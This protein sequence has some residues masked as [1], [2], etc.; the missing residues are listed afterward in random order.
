MRLSCVV[1]IFVVVAIITLPLLAQSP[2][3]NINGLVSDPATG[4]ITG[5]EIVAV[6][7]GTGVQYTTK[8]NGEGI[9]FL[10]NLPPG[11]YRLQVSKVGFK[12]II[13]PD[14][15]LN[16]QDALSV[17]FTLP[18][19]ALHEIVTVE[20]GA[21]LV[22]TE[23]PAVSTVVD[24]QFAE[25]LPMNGRSFQTLIQLTP[26]VVLTP[27]GITDSGQFSVN[28]QRS[29]S[30]YWMVDGVSANIGI[31]VNLNGNPGN[32]LAGASGAFSALGGTNS[33]VSVDAMQ[34]FRI[35]T[36]TFAPEFG[37]TPGAQISIVTRSGTNQLHGTLFDYLRN[38]LFDANDW[39]ADN[40]HL[41]KPQE[42][43]NDFGG[44]FSGPIFK[45]RTFFFF[46][47]EGLRLRLPQV[48]QTEV[49]DF[50][51]R[52]SASAAIQPY[53][54]AFPL[55]NG[56]D[57]SSTGTAQFN[58]SFSN[59]STLD[60][61]SIRVDHR[62]NNKVTLFGRYSYSPSEIDV[63]GG[64][65]PSVVS[66][67]NINT[68]TAT[69]GTTWLPTSTIVNDLRVNYSRV[70]ARGSSNLDNFG[71]ALPLASVPYPAPFT[72][73]DA[74]FSFDILSITPSIE[75]GD[76]QHQR[77]K[78]FN[79]LEN[80]STQRG[81]HSLKFGIDFRRLSPEFNPA[82][83]SQ[84]PFFTDVSSAETGNMLFSIVESSR[85]GTLLFRNLGIF[86]E[87]TWGVRPRLTLTYG[88]RWDVDFAPTSVNG[89]S[90]TAAL[91]FGNPSNIALAP[92]GTP[93]FHTPFGGIAP[94]LGFAYELPTRHNWQTI[95]RGGVG[96]FYDL[97][98][99]ELGNGVFSFAYP[100]GNAVLTSGGQFPLDPITAAPPTISPAEASSSSGVI[101]LFDP[102]L[103]LPRTFQW[104]LALQQSLGL[105]QAITASYVGAAGRRLI[106]TEYVLNPDPNIS[107][108]LGLLNHGISDYDALQVQFQRR[109][110]RG[111]QAIA[112]YSWSHSID[113]ASASSW[114]VRSNTFVPLA[115][116]GSNRGPSD[117]DIRNAFST[118]V[119][120]DIPALR[121]NRAVTSA[122]QGWSLQ[123]VIQ[124]RSASP[125][126]V[127]DPNFFPGL[128]NYL[129]NVR[130]DVVADQPFYLYGPQ[131]PGGK[132]INPSAFVSPPTDANGQ[133]LRQG[134]L[135][136]NA[137]RGFGATQWDFAIHRD[138]LLTESLKL[139]LRAEIFNLLN[140]PNFGPP[141]GVLDNSQFGLS[142]QMLGQSLDQNPG[143]G[144]FSALYQIGGPRSAQFALKL[145]F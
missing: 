53:L 112:S 75:V 137:L 39:F 79:I 108:E 131:L 113:T 96:I 4:V 132:A 115:I 47:Y 62:V 99:S 72:N 33:L 45:N 1:R 57:N 94:R 136:R 61:Y 116:A 54:N 90:L 68:Q 123:S 7:D 89:P 141:N 21:S 107:T 106:Q 135:G 26:G 71:G 70:D 144:G 125:V 24:R 55:P 30:N 109:L 42:R 77:Q 97:A 98:T 102:N 142:S 59:R 139:Q 32:G 9:Y 103:K 12:T 15:V 49:P 105:Q 31:G 28:G 48:Q 13:K 92:A 121:A 118:G 25:N 19:G 58:A 111:L 51:A 130:P 145:M 37:R 101:L 64:I 117:F 88:V 126:N 80:L 143:G 87:D 23:S 81:A 86:A 95:L 128:Q 3:G 60:A 5:A 140:H 14:I 110:S 122:L 78:Q 133:A 38:D 69:V 119:T 129:T 20:G 34:E 100:F 56:P 36:S 73:R 74:N 11:P 104:N 41:P 22:N 50:N 2:N 76:G 65:G 35:Q 67:G 134:D 63:R 138:F 85:S 120:Y 93:I 52:Q 43:Q 84:Q 127:I 16:V 83:Y 46:S 18:I 17:N 8:T 40:A 29:S 10:A 27:S 44:T 91:N 6:N 124:V 114:G 82:K 66:V